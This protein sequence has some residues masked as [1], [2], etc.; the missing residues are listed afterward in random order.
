MC[1]KPMQNFSWKIYRIQKI[2][3]SN[4]EDALVEDKNS[5]RMIFY[6][7]F[8]SFGFHHYI[9]TWDSLHQFRAADIELIWNELTSNQ[10]CNM[11][12]QK[13]SIQQTTAYCSLSYL[14]TN[15]IF[16]L[17]FQFFKNRFFFGFF[18]QIW[19]SYSRIF[20]DTYLPTWCT[21]SNFLISELPSKLSFNDIYI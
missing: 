4:V 12:M 7:S 14:A 18:Y 10:I 8:I 6:L 15:K 1:R 20:T 11:M 9:L 5:C 19:A 13:S 2:Y 16:Y 21:W 3:I 17:P